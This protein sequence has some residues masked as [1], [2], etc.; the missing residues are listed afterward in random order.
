MNRTKQAWMVGGAAICLALGALAWFWLFAKQEAPAPKVPA[1]VQKQASYVASY[2]KEGEVVLYNVKTK[3]QTDVLHLSQTLPKTSTS[4][5]CECNPKTPQSFK[6]FVPVVVTVKKG[7]TIWNLQKQWTPDINPVLLFP[8]LRE[9]NPNQPLHPIYP[10]EKRVLLKKKDPS[11]VLSFS[12]LN[13]EEVSS[14]AT[15]S[16]QEKGRFFVFDKDPKHG[17]L[18]AY[19]PANRVLLR[20]EEQKG[21]LHVR[22]I[23]TL[24]SSF[25][26]V[27]ELHVSHSYAWL[28]DETRTKVE[29]HPFSTTEVKLFQTPKMD[30]AIA[31]PWGF[32]YT[33]DHYLTR[34]PLKGSPQTIEM[35]DRTSDLVEVNAFLYALNTFGKNKNTSLLYQIHPSR[36]TIQTL[37]P[38]NS[39]DSVILSHGNQQ[40]LYVGKIEKVKQLNGVIKEEPKV[41]FMDVHLKKNKEVKSGFLFSPSI[42][43]WDR[44]LYVYDNG[45]LRLYR[46]GESKQETAL[47]IPYESFTVF[48]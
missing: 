13:D 33:F 12:E 7:D 1:Y 27:S 22:P 30:R 8:L 44:Y 21:K 40:D 36:L 47:R 9:L 14:K 26:N 41:L 37:Y 46:A 6:H 11:A 3:K 23:R 17:A 5:P 48:P 16:A 28:I 42:M 4:S 29:M 15:A 38:I 18:Y 19:S 34:L 20:I 32:Y 10:Q 35:G 39:A 31:T 45:T 2:S 25:A 43:S 24:R